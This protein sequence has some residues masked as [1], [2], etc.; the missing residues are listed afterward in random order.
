MLLLR[1]V[2][3][4]LGQGPVLTHDVLDDQQP[5]GTAARLDARRPVE[6]RVVPMGSRHVVLRDRVR[7]RVVVARCDA[8]K[9]VV[10]RVLT[11][12]VQAVR[13]Q[14]GRLVVVLEVCEPRHLRVRVV[15]FR[16]V[17]DERDLEG[18][19]GP[20]FDRRS[21]RRVLVV[22]AGGHVDHARVVLER[23]VGRFLERDMHFDPAHRELAGD[24]LA[25]FGG[26]LPL[27]EAAVAAKGLLR[28]GDGPE[29]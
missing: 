11:A 13:V 5:D 14:V 3:N 18:V 12:D 19:A 15:L 16:Q 6:V 21:H 7:V 29:H 9:D 26:V 17:V 25:A 2:P 24:V 4:V 1:E 28:R 8:A 27:A 20:D 10:R 22:A 23:V